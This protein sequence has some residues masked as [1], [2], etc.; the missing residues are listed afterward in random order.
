MSSPSLL[1]SSPAPL[2]LPPPVPPSLQTMA[3]W[4]ATDG[5]PAAATELLSAVMG[6]LAVWPK[7]FLEDEDLTARLTEK[8]SLLPSRVTQ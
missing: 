2:L 3:Q 8:E 1:T 6:H 5:Q 4:V 7:R